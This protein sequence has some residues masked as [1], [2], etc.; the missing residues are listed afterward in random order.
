[1]PQSDTK[2]YQADTGESLYRRSLYTMWKRT[3]PPPSMEI[4]NAPSR[5]TFCVRRDRTNTP[6]Q[7]L[8]LLNDPQF[9]ETSR[10]LAD[11]ALARVADFNG[12]IDFIT[13]RLVNRTLDPEERRIIGESL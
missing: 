10:A 3:A 11:R 7:A 6:L 2:S 9:V 13:L 8:V 4:L 5:E 1:M 12:R